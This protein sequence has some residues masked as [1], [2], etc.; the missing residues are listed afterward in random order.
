M[1]GYEDKEL[2]NDFSI[3]EKL[4]RPEDVKSSWKMQQELIS[5]Q[6]SR[7]EMEF[8][9]QHKE[10]HWVDILSRA[11]AVFDKNGKAI[12]IVGTHVD[13]SVR[14]RYEEEI[15][16]TKENLKNTFD[17][18]PSIIG[19]AN[20]ETGYFTETNKAI[21]RILGHTTEEFMSRKFIEFIH[22]DDQQR[23]MD[24]ISQQMKGSITISFENRYLCKDGSY[25]WIAWNSTEVDKN[26]IIT[27]IGSDINAQKQAEAHIHKLSTAVQ[28]SPSMIVITD[29]NGI[30]EY[31][32]P[33]FTEVSGYSISESIG[34][35]SNILKSGKQDASFY[36]KLWKTLEA[37]KV[38]R[39]QFHNKKKNGELFWEAASIAAIINESGIRTNFVK[40]GEDITLQKDIESELIIAL[41]KAQQSDQLKSAFLANMSHEIRTP[42]NGILGFI[43]L[44]AETDL[45]KAQIVKYTGIINKSGDRLLTTINNIFDISK[46]EAGEIDV[47]IRETYLNSLM[48]ELHTF[49]VIEAKQKGLSFFCKPS[50]P[51]EKAKVFTDSQKL[52]AILTNLISNAIK[53]TNKGHII[54]GYYLKEKFIE[55]YVEDTGIGVPKNR[56][57]AI[58]NRFEQ[59]DMGNSRVLEGSGLGLAISKAYVEML[60]GEISLISE[61]G[62]GSVFTFTIP[63]IETI[64]DRNEPDSKTV[65]NVTANAGKFNLLIVEDDEISAELLKLTLKGMFK[66]IIFVDKGKD[67]VEMCRNMPDLDLVLMDIKMPGMNGYDATRE[68]RRFNK[69]LVIIAQTAHAMLGDKEKA[70]QAGCNDYITKP[71]DKGLLIEMIDKLLK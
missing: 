71:I 7:F 25:K 58:F 59:A 5:K 29:S 44:L 2:P 16:A 69:D 51:T 36:K 27:I 17:I 64:K 61:E 19:K 66:K 65:E 48:D 63:Y 30:V 42:M 46:I 34:R 9:M 39:G 3:W 13:I 4:I 14:K 45:N 57:R 28:Q 52:H 35:E 53:C 55:F 67:A 6:R 60:G 10:G 33:K 11:E 54:F 43:N 62:K 50:L 8:K 22:P 68:I 40:I 23:T 41:E 1:L 15:R 12:R 49:F 31:V 26:G 47:S 18:S 37:G 20:I 32:N 38:W 24:E 56:M 70:I 21:T